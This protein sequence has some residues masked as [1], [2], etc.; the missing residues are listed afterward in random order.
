MG[1][2]NYKYDAVIHKVSGQ[3]G[4]YVVF[5]Y[6]I[7]MEFGKGR[8]NVDDLHRQAH[9]YSWPEPPLSLS[10]VHSDYL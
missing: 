9:F 4:A 8:V 1:G 2:K 10:E 3:D 5:P 7:K 6:D